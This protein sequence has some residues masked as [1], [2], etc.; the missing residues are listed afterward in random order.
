MGLWS[1]ESIKKRANHLDDVQMSSETAEI[2]C[3]KWNGC[4]VNGNFQFEHTLTHIHFYLFLQ[5][6]DQVRSFHVV[7]STNRIKRNANGDSNSSKRINSR[8]FVMSQERCDFAFSISMRDGLRAN[9]KGATRDSS[10]HF[11]LDFRA[12]WMQHATHVNSLDWRSTAGERGRKR[13]N[14]K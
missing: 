13:R 8:T 1:G 10:T 7:P 5:R 14:V 12:H 4:V 2:A 6:P 3:C 11:T 9:I